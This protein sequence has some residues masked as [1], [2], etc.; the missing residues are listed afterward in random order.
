MT[1]VVTDGHDVAL[2]DERDCFSELLLDRNLPSAIQARCCQVVQTIFSL[3]TCTLPSANVANT[4]PGWQ[5][6]AG[7]FLARRVVGPSTKARERYFLDLVSDYYSREELSQ[8]ASEGVED[9]S[10]DPA[11]RDLGFVIFYLLQDPSP[12]ETSLIESLAKAGR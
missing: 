9:G 8:S 1:S 7:V 3:T 6:G 11:L 2:S 4:P 12:A 5:R 10:A